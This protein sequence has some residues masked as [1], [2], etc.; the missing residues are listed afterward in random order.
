MV[1]FAM[2]LEMAGKIADPLGQDQVVTD[3]SVPIN[4]TSLSQ[5]QNAT[6]LRGLPRDWWA[7][8]LLGHTDFSEITPNEVT[9]FRVFNVGGVIL[10]RSVRP[11]RIYVYDGGNSRIL[12]LSH[13]GFCQGGGDPCTVLI[14]CV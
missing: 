7:D 3:A 10:D 8:S 6:P 4:S 11:N 13:L 2:R 5:Q 14:Q 12:G 9:D 1:V